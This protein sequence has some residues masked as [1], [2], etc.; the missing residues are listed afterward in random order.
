MT[1]IATL[2]NR[3]MKEEGFKEAYEESQA[4]FELARQLIEA[5]VQNGLSQDELAE[6]METSQSTIA[7]LESGKAM[8]SMKTLRRFAKA[9]NSEVQILFKPIKAIKQRAVA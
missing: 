1:K 2:K 8:P 6:L 3:W 9:T 7:R 5:R 4:E